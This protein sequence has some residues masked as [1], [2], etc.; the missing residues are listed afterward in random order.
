MAA[1]KTT[2]RKR[3]STSGRPR[4]G[5]N[6]QSSLW[7]RGLA[8][9]SRFGWRVVQAT[10]EAVAGPDDSEVLGLLKAQH[11]QVDELFARL[12]RPQPA[13]GRRALVEELAEALVT[14]AAI[15]ERHFYPAIRVPATRALVDESLEEHVAMKRTLLDLTTASPE[16]DDFLAK[17]RVLK[18]QVTHHARMEEEAKLFPLVAGLLSA[19]QRQAMAQEM[20]AT[21][22]DLQ[23][24]RK[25]LGLL[26]ADLQEA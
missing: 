20:T 10:A 21:M 17:V 2:Q 13:A 7:A 1:E 16:D 15:E 19:D 22:V 6:G 9:V 4:Q 18:E 14:H 5:S 3:S 25:A 24:P 11:R 23:G 8:Q 26:R 12:E